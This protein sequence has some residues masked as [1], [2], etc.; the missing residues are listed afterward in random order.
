MK[1]N[2]GITLI[3]LIITIIVLIILAAIS[4]AVLTGEDGIITKA[5]QGAQNYQNAAIEEQQALNSIYTQAGTQLTTGSTSNGGT[6]VNQGV[7]SGGIGLSSQEH[8]WLEQMHNDVAA[9]ASMPARGDI[10]PTQSK[11]SIYRAAPGTKTSWKIPVIGYDKFSLII[12]NTTAAYQLSYSVVD[13]NGNSLISGNFGPQWSEYI[14][15]PENGV[16]LIVSSPYDHTLT[17]SV[18]I[19]TKDSPYNPDNQH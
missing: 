9:I 8:E 6:S 5:K 19:L 13:T 10:N 15:I 12:D 17:A 16:M 14:Q 7:T 4:I 18:S 11:N 2:K 1:S 3:A